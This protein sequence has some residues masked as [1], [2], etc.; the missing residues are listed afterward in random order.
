[1]HLFA[2]PSYDVFCQEQLCCDLL[3]V[4][5][6][7]FLNTVCCKVTWIMF[8]IIISLRKSNVY[9]NGFGYHHGVLRISYP[10]TD[11][12]LYNDIGPLGSVVLR[13]I[14]QETLFHSYL[15]RLL[16]MPINFSIFF[17]STL[18]NCLSWLVG[19]VTDSI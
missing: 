3:F 10:L 19:F 17:V 13:F 2:A 4:R 5:K 7:Y 18:I 1:M 14:I 6:S 11:H 16:I 9:L 12:N 8:I 15:L